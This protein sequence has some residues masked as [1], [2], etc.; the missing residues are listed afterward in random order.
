ME[1]NHHHQTITTKPS[2][3]AIRHIKRFDGTMFQNWNGIDVRI[4]RC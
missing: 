3:D 1:E 4:Q 2:L